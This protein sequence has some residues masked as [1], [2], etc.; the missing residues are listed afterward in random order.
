MSRSGEGPESADAYESH[1]ALTTAKSPGRS[2]P[3]L[4]S[5]R[6]CLRSAA[7]AHQREHELEH[8][9]EVEVQRERAVHRHLGRDLTV[10]ATVEIH[11][12]QLLRVVGGEA[13]EDADAEERD[14]PL[15]A[16]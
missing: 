7:V 11:L 8:V 12:L 4:F 1:F 3:G 2:A 14:R 13:R 5:F 10:A 6:R 9:D 16:R 15:Q